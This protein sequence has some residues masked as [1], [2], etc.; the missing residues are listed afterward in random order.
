[1]MKRNLSAASA[2]GAGNAAIK[3]SSATTNFISP[4]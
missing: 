1:L 2:L 3:A 4:P